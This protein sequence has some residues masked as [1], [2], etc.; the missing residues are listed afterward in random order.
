M[1]AGILGAISIGFA[2]SFSNDDKSPCMSCEDLT[3]LR[4]PDVIISDTELIEA[5]ETYCKLTGIIC[6]EIGFELLLPSRWNARFVMEGNGGFAGSCWTDTTKVADGYA[7]GST[8]T[9][10]QGKSLKADW[11][12]SNMERQLN[13]A[14]LAVH[15]TAI[16]SKEI[17]RHY[18]GSGPK[19]SYFNGCSRGGGQGIIEAQRYPNDFDGIVAGAPTID[20]LGFAAE[21]IRNSQVVYP[22]PLNLT[23]P[24]ISPANLLLLQTTILGQCDTLDGIK[25]NILNDPRDCDFNVD[26]LPRCPDDSICDDCFTSAQIEAVR[27]VY[28]GLTIQNEEIHP[29]FPFGCE[30]E[31]GGWLNWVVGPNS[32][33]MKLNYPTLQL[34]LGAETFKYLVFQDPDWDYSSY[35]FSNFP[36]DT[37]IV[38]SYLNATS[39]DYSA[40]KNHGGKMIIYHGWNDPVLS[41][42]A[43]LKHYK[44]AKKED[45]KIEEFMRLYLLPGVLHCGAGP[46]PDPRDVD[47]LELIRDWVEQGHAPERVIMSKKVKGEVVFTRPVFPYPGIAEYN[48]YGDP[49]EESSFNER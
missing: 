33:S 39:T 6:R 28:N 18:Y 21:C 12:L 46:G 5:G 41:A 45:E 48:G 38:S 16:I 11:A 1:L 40:F 7:S 43:T 44:A 22:D 42:L 24:T 4:I 25:D 9:G 13:Y 17:L 8:D 34:N 15:R 19:F 36:S 30:N 26:L 47:W 14:H 31:P 20:F 3:N 27:E 2:Q 35:D 49:N 29:G 32:I 37:R 23:E 10:H